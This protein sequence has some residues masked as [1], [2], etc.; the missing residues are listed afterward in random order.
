MESMIRDGFDFDGNAGFLKGKHNYGEQYL[1]IRNRKEKHRSNIIKS[2][3]TQS[4]N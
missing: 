4:K 1:K 2:D 3:N